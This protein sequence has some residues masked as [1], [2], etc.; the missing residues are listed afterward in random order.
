MIFIANA[1]TPNDDGNN[2]I[3]FAQGNEIEA[4]ATFQIFDRWGELIFKVENA[5]IND[6]NFGWNGMY[7]GEKA[8]GVFA[9][10]VEI[11]FNDGDVLQEGGS[12][13][14]IR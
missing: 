10:K 7:K 13:I 3:L 9:W 12:T 5:P 4:K 14:L 8:Q 6:E 11:I 1:F 2:D